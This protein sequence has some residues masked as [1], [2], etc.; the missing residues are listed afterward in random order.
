MPGR[1]LFGFR[2]HGWV[3]VA[4]AA[5]SYVRRLVGQGFG[6]WRG[7]RS[8]GVSVASPVAFMGAGFVS[9]FLATHLWE[10]DAWRQKLIAFASG[11]LFGLC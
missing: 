11:L 6:A 10:V 3:R 4:L 1:L 5:L 2:L 8:T 9:V 7:C